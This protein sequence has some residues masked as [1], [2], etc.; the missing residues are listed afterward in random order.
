[1][2]L[3][4]ELCPD[5]LGSLQRSPRSPNWI[6]GEGRKEGEEG[7]KGKGG[8]KG[9]GPPMSEVR[10]HSWRA[11]IKLS[12]KQQILGTCSCPLTS[13][14]NWLKIRHAWLRQWCKSNPCAK[15]CKNC[16][17]RAASAKG[18]NIVFSSLV[19]PSLLTAAMVLHIVLRTNLLLGI[20]AYSAGEGVGEVLISVEHK[21]SSEQILWPNVILKL[22]IFLLLHFF[23][24]IKVRFACTVKCVIF[25]TRKA[26]P[27]KPL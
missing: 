14:S 20:Q 3:V 17:R 13:Y 22:S 8:R 1:M 12:G 11:T 7:E 16:P 15:K 26:G 25:W 23:L 5:P 6:K 19:I 18:W 2:R 27:K 10:W 9:D 24:Q 4:A 21:L